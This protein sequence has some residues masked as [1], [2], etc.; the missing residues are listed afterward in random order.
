LTSPVSNAGTAMP[1]IAMQGHAPKIENSPQAETSALHL[2]EIP[3]EAGPQRDDRWLDSGN[4]DLLQDTER[5]LTAIRTVNVQIT[6]KSSNKV[7]SLCRSATPPALNRPALRKLDANAKLLMRPLPPESTSLSQQP[8]HSTEASPCSLHYR[9]QAGKQILASTTSDGISRRSGLP[10]GAQLTVPEPDSASKKIATVSSAVSATSA[11]W[12]N[13]DDI[14]DSDIPATPSPPR[15]RATSTPPTV[16][17][18]D[19]EAIKSP[20]LKAKLP[21]SASASTTIRS[22]DEN[23]PYLMAG[24]FPRITATIRSTPPSTD[25]ATPTWHE[26]ILLYDPIVLED[27]TAWLN[28]Q[29]LRLEVKR[30]K[31]KVKIRGRKKKDAFPELPEYETVEEELKPWMVQRWCEDR[32]ICCL[33][34]EGLNGARRNRY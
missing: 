18:L 23:W 16:Q 24:L 25:L 17:A 34:R 11:E 6:T 13:I 7:P 31:P 20:S 27:L 22:N 12:V 33:W 26:K 3:E 10:G 19:L 28:E 9:T 14:S 32:S 4:D 5:N 29:G 1:A 15:R 21:V 2:L 8:S 30:M